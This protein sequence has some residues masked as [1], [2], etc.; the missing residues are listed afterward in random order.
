[1]KKI[2]NNIIVFITLRIIF[3]TVF[4]L[5]KNKCIRVVDNIMQSMYKVYYVF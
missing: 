3:V 1:M 2:N 5:H 4:Y